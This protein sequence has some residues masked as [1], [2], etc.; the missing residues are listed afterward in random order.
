MHTW[1]HQESIQVLRQPYQS[2]AQP[3][4]AWGYI[5]KCLEKSC[6]KVTF[7]SIKLFKKI[8]WFGHLLNE[9][10]LSDINRNW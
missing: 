9:D 10:E 3:H 5:S 8:K 2:L 6:E 4:P 1:K 7:K